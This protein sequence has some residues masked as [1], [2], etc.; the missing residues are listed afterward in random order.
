M[1]NSVFGKTMENLRKR[2][3]IELVTNFFFFII[4]SVTLFTTYYNPIYEFKN[5]I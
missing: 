2:V 3:N 1:N 4:Y 5:K